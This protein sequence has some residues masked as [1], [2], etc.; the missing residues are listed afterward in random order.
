MSASTTTTENPF[1]FIE[2]SPE[3]R[4]LLQDMLAKCEK[5]RKSWSDGKVVRALRQLRDDATVTL[6][7][8]YGTKQN[9]LST[10]N[11][12]LPYKYAA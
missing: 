4:E 9:F 8:G 11:L 6:P 10:I 12:K 5:A 1:D 2:L 7:A 3:E